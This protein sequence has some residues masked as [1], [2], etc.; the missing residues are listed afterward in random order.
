MDWYYYAIA[1]AVCIVVGVICFVLGSNHRKKTAEAEIGS[2]ETEANRILSDAMKNAEAK[3]KE[4]LLE[5][6]D[7]IHQLRSDADKEIKERRSEVQRQERRL[8]QKEESLDRK[9]E[10]HEKKEEKLAEKMKLADEKA[11]ELEEL[12]TAQRDMLKKISGYSVEEAKAELLKSVEEELVHDKAV[13]IKDYEQRT[14]DEAESIAR[15][16]IAL[17]IQRCAADHTSE[18]TVSVVALPNDEMKGRIIGREGRNI[19]ALETLTG[20]DLIIDDTPEAI[21]VSC[22]DPIRREIAR[23]TLEKLISDGRI[24]PT[25]IEEMYEKAKCEVEGVIKSEGERAVLDT[26]VRG[27]NHELV[28]LLGKLHFRTSFGQNVLKHS[29]EVSYI[30][31]LIAAEMG[32]DVTLAKRAGLLHDI[33]K[34]LDH[35]M[36]GSHIQLGVDVARKYKESEAVI[37]AIHAHHGDVEAKTVVACIVQAADAISASRPGARRENLE[38]YIK[39][40]ERLEEIANS[41]NGVERSF[42]IQAG[43]EIRIVVKPNIVDDD[44]MVLVARD[45]AKQ[46]EE[47]L[48]YPGQIK[49][50][51]IRESRVVDYAK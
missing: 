21:T 17:S 12:K 19:T 5:A 2:A 10:N 22:F 6:K 43:R 50:N 31:G 4:T 16:I 36:E 40:L 46:I 35:E 24:H 45:V 48:D 26:G 3:K 7:E 42:A 39:R 8:A 44:K 33:G 27:I 9:I 47:E 38:N 49:V 30:S 51:V 29:L 14:K 1:A 25:R 28:K 11:V 13:M 15:N 20:V 23:L 18:T 37:H 32:E 41:F 34:A